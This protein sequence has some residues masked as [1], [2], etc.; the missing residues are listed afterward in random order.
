MCIKTSCL[1]KKTILW[2]LWRCSFHPAH[3]GAPDTHRPEQQIEKSCINSLSRDVF[4]HTPKLSH[5]HKYP[6]LN[7]AWKHVSN[8]KVWDVCNWDVMKSFY[9]NEFNKTPNLHPSLL[10]FLHSPK[11]DSVLKRHIRTLWRDVC[12][13]EDTS[14]SPVCVCICGNIFIGLFTLHSTLRRNNALDQCTNWTKTCP[15]KHALGF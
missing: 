4:Y 8:E 6:A 13:C 5:A 14:Q 2:Y 10:P 15:G 3:E 11:W 7:L 9:S 1:M 12:A